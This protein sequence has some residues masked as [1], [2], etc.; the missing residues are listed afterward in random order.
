MTNTGWTI[1]EMLSGPELRDKY[2]GGTKLAAVNVTT[3]G[4]AVAATA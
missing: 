4:F 3:S 2:V 1:D